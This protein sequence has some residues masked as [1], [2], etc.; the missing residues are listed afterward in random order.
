MSNYTTP[1]PVTNLKASWVNSS[2]SSLVTPGIKLSW[3]APTVTSGTLGHYTVYVIL[4]NKAT[5]QMEKI[6][7]AELNRI[8]LR[9]NQTNSA[10]GTYQISPPPTSVMFPFFW[11]LPDGYQYATKPF[12][13]NGV[14]Q[15][16]N[17]SYSFSVV[18]GILENEDLIS[19]YTGVTAYEPNL[20]TLLIPTHFNPRFQINSSQPYVDNPDNNNG[21]GSVATNIQNSYDEIAAS[22]EMVLSTPLSWR[23]VVPEFGTPDQTFSNKIDT[24]VIKAALSRWEPRATT[25][26][27]VVMD[28]SGNSNNNPG[29]GEAMVNVQITGIEK[30]SI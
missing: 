21:T 10:S 6:Q 23:T 17:Q 12:L 11:T 20:Q 26:I 22:V 29:V 9:N 13:N 8:P 4:Q 19:N 14:L 28:D 7:F 30:T 1:P 18:S 3:T 5:L 15:P 2:T 27:N 25:Q 16:Y 24:N